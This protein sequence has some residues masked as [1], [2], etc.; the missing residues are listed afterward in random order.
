MATFAGSKRRRL[1]MASIAA[2]L[3]LALLA[4][5]CSSRTKA[6]VSP[7]P[8]GEATG[9]LEVDPNSPLGLPKLIGLEPIVRPETVVLDAEKTPVDSATILN[10]AA[11][12][13]MDPARVPCDFR[14]TFASA[15]AGLKVG[16]VLASDVTPTLPHGLLVKVTE[17]DGG[18]VLATEATLGDAL[19]QGEFLMERQFTAADIQAMTLAPGV[20]ATGETALAAASVG[21]AGTGIP[22]PATELASRVL[23][24]AQANGRVVAGDGVGLAFGYDMTNV[25][26]GSGAVANGHVGFEVGCGSYGGLTWKKVAGVPIYPNGAHFEAKC[27][28]K[29]DGSI[30][31]TA[32]QKAS[33]EKSVDIATIY[34]DAITFFVGPVPVVLIPTITVTANASGAVEAQMSFG[35]SEHF[36]AQV[37]IVYNKGFKLIKDFDYGFDSTV[38]EVKA[39][40]TATAGVS[41]G[42]ALMLYGLA[43]PQLNET[44]YAKF[45]G[46]PPGE[47][48]IWCLNGGIE[49][50]VQLHI[51]LGIKTL[52]Y[53]PEKL[54]GEEFELS[55]AG[56]VAPTVTVQGGA[57]GMTIFPTSTSQ[58]PNINASGNDLEEGALPIAWAS[59]GNALGTSQS[60]QAFSLSALS[61]G[62][63]TVTATVTDGDGATATASITVTA[64]DATPTA[65][66]LV[67]NGS[68]E[69]VDGSAASGVTGGQLL[70][71][72]NSQ[73]PLGQ[74]KVGECMPNV[75][76]SGG[77]TVTSGGACDHVVYL[78]K[79]G[80]FPL[81][82]TVTDPD[83][84]T[85]QDSLTVTVTDPV[86]GSPPA[87]TQITAL[88]TSSNPNEPL[89][90]G[91]VI[92][93]GDLVRLSTQYSNSA[94]AG[95][96]VKYTWEMQR[97]GI[98]QTGLWSTLVAGDW[99]PA[100]GSV[101]FFT[102]PTEYGKSYT[103]TFR[104]TVYDASTNEQYYSDTH[105]LAFTGTPA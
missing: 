26:L 61:L 41:V 96:S 27:G 102:V 2:S 64:L 28:A 9:V 32:S 29:Q 82:A 6:E 25:D 13:P 91:C 30:T 66:I 48:P 98:G 52:D 47:R 23:N 99:S 67:Q 7:T 10:A 19:E 57:T 16:S 54:F 33:I 35:A 73:T 88:R 63:H 53:G 60:G 69:W 62:T 58:P 77:L 36:S 56:N 68:G 3:A 18:T 75:S 97:T 76:W 31:V 101:R 17:V 14:L 11:C 4:S 37:G 83:G 95:K 21:G 84:K 22:L 55:C 46:K 70:V 103:Y 104:V 78:S 1:T 38:S 59:D 43:G 93:S 39:R 8:S 44:I 72:V 51:D 89:C 94:Q 45:V 90:D 100:T 71:R 79:A 34:L 50:S 80:S 65:Q 92:R 86:V 74:I 15:P 85:V 87:F 49:A 20:T 5:G 24:D 105:S 12:E 40:V 42:E 81:T